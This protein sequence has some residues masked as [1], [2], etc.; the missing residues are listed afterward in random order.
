MVS[1]Y[2]CV[3]SVLNEPRRNY[4]KDGTEVS[5]FWLLI[6]RNDKMNNY[7]YLK[8]EAYASVAK[9]IND[10]IHIGDVVSVRSRPVSIKY[11]HKKTGEMRHGIIFRVAMLEFICHKKRLMINEFGGSEFPELDERQFQ[12]WG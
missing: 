4:K 3:G 2:V 1:C 9:F 6:K 8:F 10:Y 7:D 12:Y 11:K 5:S